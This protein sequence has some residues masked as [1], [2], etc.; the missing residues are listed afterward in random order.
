[1]I[2]YRCPDCRSP[3]CGNAVGEVVTC[4]ECGNESEVPF[5]R[6]SL[7]SKLS[8]KAI[9]SGVAGIA[10]LALAA[11]I[12]LI[13]ALF[14]TAK[15]QKE[16]AWKTATSTAEVGSITI[17]VK[18]GTVFESGQV[19]ADPIG[20]FYA[21]SHMH[22]NFT[23][24]IATANS[25]RRFEYRSPSKCFDRSPSIRCWDDQ[26]N[27]LPEINAMPPAKINSVSFYADQPLEDPFVV[28]R[29]AP[30]AKEVLIEVP[31]SCVGGAGLIYFKVRIKTNAEQIRERE[32]NRVVPPS[33]LD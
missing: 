15:S 19:F 25:N 27:E 7:A 14:P 32:A 10:L 22:L 28:A 30:T 11:G 21:S 24:Q 18:D 2:S 8:T 1:M 13:V 16:N 9:L 4:V 3:L 26:G 6:P 5:K 29:A 31:A 17:S 12:V 23:L 33:M 20:G